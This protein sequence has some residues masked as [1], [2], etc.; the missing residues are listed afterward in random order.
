M[1]PY[2]T[3]IHGLD[4][5]IDTKSRYDSL[6]IQHWKTNTDSLSMLFG[7]Y[8]LIT[9]YWIFAKDFI[10]YQQW[11]ERCRYRPT[12]RLQKTPAA[13][14]IAQ[15]I[16]LFVFPCCTNGVLQIAPWLVLTGFLFDTNDRSLPDICRFQL[17][18]Q[19]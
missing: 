13:I 18:P 14:D 7:L 1:L 16:L 10:Q 19:H 9:I 15:D 4:D 11:K 17:A 6:L 5:D 8:S 3:D 2:L 12:I